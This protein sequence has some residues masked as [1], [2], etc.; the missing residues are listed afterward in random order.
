[1]IAIIGGRIATMFKIDKKGAS[2]EKIAKKFSGS[3]RILNP[4]V[5]SA[6]GADL[7]TS[8]G[9]SASV[10]KESVEMD[11][12]LLLERWQKISGIV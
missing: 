11:A 6:L 4:A 8:G 3:T 9:Q 10:S 5:A 2:K 12:S 7:P 1:M